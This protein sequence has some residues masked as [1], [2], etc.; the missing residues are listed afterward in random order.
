M[1][2]KYTKI[3]PVLLRVLKSDH[4]QNSHPFRITAIRIH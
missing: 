2:D 4:Y 1:N 3:C